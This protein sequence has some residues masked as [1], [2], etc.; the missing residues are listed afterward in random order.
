M[1]LKAANPEAEHS[2][3]SGIATASEKSKGDEPEKKD[4]SERN[5]AAEEKNS[6]LI[7]STKIVT[8]PRTSLTF[9][10]PEKITLGWC[11]FYGCMILAAVFTARFVPVAR[12]LP[13]WG[14]I[15]RKMTGGWPCLSCGMTRSFDWFAQGRFGDSFLINPL[16]FCLALFG[17]LITL[18]TLAAPLRPP[19]PRLILGNKVRIAAGIFLSAAILGDWAFLLIRHHLGLWP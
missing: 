14:C 12:I 4:E 19:R 5:S 16:G 18:Y 7:C 2:G 1:S 11:E 17:V 3:A 10:R 13:G 9:F 8:P 15:F 6:A